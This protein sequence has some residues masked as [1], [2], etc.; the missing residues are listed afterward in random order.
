[1]QRIVNSGPVYYR[2]EQWL[3]ATPPTHGIFTRLG[4]VSAKPWDSLNVGS[5]VGDDPADVMRNKQLMI[6]ALGLDPGQTC[7]VWQV[8]GNTTLVMNEPSMNG[9][10]LQQADGMVTDKPGLALVMRFA[11]C[12]PLLFYDPVKQV[13]GMAH[14][15]WR[16]TVAGAG[17]SVIRKMQ[18]VYGSK[19]SDIEA[20]IGPSIGPD[21]YQVGAEVVEAV[22]KAFGVI[23]NL[24]IHATDGSAYLNLWEANRIALLECGVGKIEVAGICTASNTAE[25]YSHRAERGRTGRFGAV[26]ALPER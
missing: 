2:F 23:D 18:E 24:V 8:H 19:P 25:F 13:I 26:M 3:A 6:E 17:P 21:Y 1:M 12:V 22:R 15:G 9:S 11:D 4:G 14:A 20:A 16:G 10:V 7:T 5:T